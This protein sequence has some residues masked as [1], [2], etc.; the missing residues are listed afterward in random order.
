MRL[1]IRTTFTTSPGA[2]RK[3]K[4]P[5]TQLWGLC[6]S[7][8][9]NGKKSITLGNHIMNS[10]SRTMQHLKETRIFGDL[11][12]FCGLGRQEPVKLT[13]FLVTEITEC[14]QRLQRVR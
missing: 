10:S 14:G 11:L 13:A 6:L 8:T 9:F 12:P 2:G 7:L 5:T 4:G 3:P 1:D